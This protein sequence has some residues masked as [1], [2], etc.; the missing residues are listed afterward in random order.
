M[1]AHLRIADLKKVMKTHI[2]LESQNP[3]KSVLVYE[4]FNEFSGLTLNI[5]PS[6]T[7]S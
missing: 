1:G 5:D 3:V 6:F 7:Q 4:N 2:G